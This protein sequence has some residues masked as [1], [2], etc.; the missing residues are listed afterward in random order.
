MTT[1]SKHRFFNNASCDTTFEK[2]R[3]SEMGR[4]FRRIW[5]VSGHGRLFLV[6]SIALRE[7]VEG[8]VAT[9]LS[10]KSFA[11]VTYTI[12]NDDLIHSLGIKC[13]EYPK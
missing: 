7:K 5:V 8:I 4:R 10:N 3:G 2:A 9:R 11:D 6:P 12:H 1:G 13:S